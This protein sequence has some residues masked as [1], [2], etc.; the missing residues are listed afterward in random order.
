MEID[1][2]FKT[3]SGDIS[4][5]LDV[6]D[7]MVEKSLQSAE[8]KDIDEIKGT[9]IDIKDTLE[10][11]RQFCRDSADPTRKIDFSINIFIKESMSAWSKKFWGADFSAS[12]E[13]SI[14]VHCSKNLLNKAIENLIIN[15]L[16]A[17]A[18][19]IYINV[20]QDGL[21]IVDNGKGITPED[22][23]MIKER[24]TTKE[25]FGGNGL[26]SVKTF[27]VA[28]GWKFYFKNNDKN[29]KYENG[30]TVGFKFSE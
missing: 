19:D 7:K 28:Q 21:E 4:S 22:L 25:G 24:G 2:S 6:V 12:S 3:F 13:K 1:D 10:E 30:L 17:E 27:A 26:K 23:A 8:E 9:L 14:Q 29:S 20:L 16:E 11:I 5:S 15:A 18:D